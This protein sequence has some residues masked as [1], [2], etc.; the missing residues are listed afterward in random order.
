[1]LHEL[2]VRRYLL[3]A[4]DR[5]VVP[6]SVCLQDK[7]SDCWVSQ[8]YTTHDATRFRDAQDLLRW[9]EVRPSPPVFFLRETEYRQ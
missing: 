7:R 1:V 5:M 6:Y 9:R 4:E 2:R 3:F 8:R